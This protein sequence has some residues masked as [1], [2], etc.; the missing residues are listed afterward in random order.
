MV[1]SL[2]KVGVALGDT[3]VIQGAGGLGL[4]ATAIAKE[5][6]AGQVIVMDRLKER[7][8]L[9][10]AFGADHIINVAEMSHPRDRLQRVRQLSGGRGADLAIE[11]VGSPQVVPEGIN[12]LRYGGTY[13]LLLGNINRGLT[14]EFDLG[15]LVTFAKKIVGLATYEPWAIPRALDFLRRTRNKYPFDRILSHKFPLTEINTAFQEAEQGRVIRAALI[16]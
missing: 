3:V 10:K 7:L 2:E 12:L 16:P 1:Y 5:K 6:G 14:V 9:A 11:L 8:E 4:Y 15:S 13:L